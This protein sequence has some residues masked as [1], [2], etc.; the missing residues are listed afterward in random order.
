MVPDVLLSLSLLFI[1]FTAFC[2]AH[3]QFLGQF[4]STW[5]SLSAHRS[6]EQLKMC[7]TEKLSLIGNSW[8]CIKN[9]KNFNYSRFACLYV[10]KFIS[11]DCLCLPVCLLGCPVLI[12]IYLLFYLFICTFFLLTLQNNNIFLQNKQCAQIRYGIYIAYIAKYTCTS[13]QCVGVHALSFS[14]LKDS[15]CT[16]LISFYVNICIILITE[17]ALGSGVKKLHLL[18]F[19]FPLSHSLS[20]SLSPS[21]PCS[22][23]IP[24]GCR[25]KVRG[26]SPQGKEEMEKDIF[27]IRSFVPLI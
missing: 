12:H 8:R 18:K 11:C 13:H 26:G 2:F 4:N 23:L 7:D 14:L 16:F 19:T 21:P 20:P 25:M 15:A 6:R 22:L 27:I 10:C 5:H 17:E 1:F 3:L 24:S 9:E